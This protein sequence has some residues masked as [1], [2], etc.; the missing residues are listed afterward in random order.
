MARS[1]VSI[2]NLALQN[3]GAIP[4]TSFEDVTKNSTLSEAFYYSAV[5]ETLRMHPWNCAIHRKEVAADATP[6]VFGYAN[7][8]QLPSSP[9][10]LRVL[11]MEYVDYEFVIEGRWL[12]TDEGVCKIQYIKRIVNPD[13]FDSLVA[14][15]IA[16]RLAVKLAYPITQSL[17]LEAKMYQNW[18]LVLSE[19]R[20]ADAQEG[21]PQ[22][23]DTSTLLNAR[24]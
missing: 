13:E 8:F 15:T 9:Y 4:I 20:C 10:C 18:K 22:E 6:P 2:C 5:D 16:A 24:L 12:L 17:S 11:Q 14:E 23:V 21:T 3:L 7:R 19:A 1:I